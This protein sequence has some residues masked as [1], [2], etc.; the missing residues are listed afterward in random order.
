MNHRTIFDHVFTLE[1]I[2]AG[3][4]FLTVLGAVLFAV[5]H[6]RARPG[7][8]PSRRSER[9]RLELFYAGALAAFA[10]FLVVYTALQNHRETR[11][12][13]PSPV[14][15]EVIGFQWCWQF[16]HRGQT[17]RPVTVTADCR[18]TRDLPTL[19]VPTGQDVRLELTSRDVIHSLWVPE[20]RYKMD[21]FPH[22]TNS[23]TLRLDREGEWIGRCAEFCGQRHYIMDFRLRAVSPEKYRKWLDGQ[24]K[25]Q[26]AGASA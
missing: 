7:I 23:F 20:L 11:G 26:A 17:A 13:D 1:A 6:R 9:N 21:A 25:A 12:A 16:T 24:A 3:I 15:V 22:H 19:M 10:I 2:I 4:V 18:N 8:N 14:R 5:V